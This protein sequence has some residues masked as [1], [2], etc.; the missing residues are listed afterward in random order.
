M[1]ALLENL[2][3]S[4]KEKYTKFW[5]EF[6]RVL[7]EGVGEDFAN[8]EKIAGLLRFASTHTDSA[9]DTVSLADYLA[10]VKEG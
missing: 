1:L 4:E 8:R 3:T 10:R 2:V 7:K 5:G 9:D 6:G